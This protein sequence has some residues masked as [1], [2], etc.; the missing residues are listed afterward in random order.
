FLGIRRLEHVAVYARF[1]GCEDIGFV[2][3][4]G[5][6][7]QAGLTASLA[8]PPRHFDSAEIRH[9]NVE[10]G[11]V[12]LM[13]PDEGNGLLAVLSLGDDLNARLFEKALDAASHDLV[14]V[15]EEHANG[16]SRVAGHSPLPFTA[17]VFPS[18]ICSLRHEC[19][20]EEH[21]SELQSR[22]KLVC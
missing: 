20:S 9:P 5:E 11:N 15:G 3:E 12:G 4:G 7:Q 17:V 16:L 21:T 19:R 10:H 2:V 14:I 8:D 6:N 22:D 13:F 18:A 1:N